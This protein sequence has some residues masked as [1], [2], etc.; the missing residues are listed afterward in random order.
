MLQPWAA[1][2][3]RLRRYLH[4]LR[5][6]YILD[7]PTVKSRL[8]RFATIQLLKRFPITLLLGLALLLSQGGVLLV[9]SLCPHLMWAAQSCDMPKMESPMD[10]S[11]PDHHDMSHGSSVLP[12]VASAQGQEPCSHCVIHSRPNSNGVLVR[13][14]DTVK[15]SADLEVPVLVLPPIAPVAVAITPREHGPPGKASRPKHVLINTF[16]I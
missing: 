7:T 1:I 5:T 4:C 3:E 15:R 14:A 9:A 12:A 16:R 10:H 8:A 2:S 13:T 6:C 11:Q